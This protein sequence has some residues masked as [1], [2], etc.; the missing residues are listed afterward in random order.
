VP[1]PKQ[2]LRLTFGFTVPGTDEVADTGLHITTLGTSPFDAAAVLDA[3]SDAN[4]D[5]FAGFYN[6][7]MGVGA[8]Q[9]GNYSK[10]DT[11]KLAAVGVDGLY[12][13]DPRIRPVTGFVGFTGAT[14]LPQSSVV[15]TFWSGLGFG[16]ANFGRMYLPHTALPLETLTPRATAAVAG[17][18]T[19][20]VAEFVS[21]VNG[22]ADSVEAASG[23]VNL[24]K[25]G[26]GTVKAVAQVGVGRVIDTQRRRRNRLNEDILYAA[27]T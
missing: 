21:A 24:S 12:L 23:V 14:V 17:A 26:L 13:T 15:A 10:L 27:V 4:I 1:Y 6:D 19:D 20:G 25:I 2:S 9:W 7:L 22:V 3:Y 16:T 18:F 11:I 8:I 5:A